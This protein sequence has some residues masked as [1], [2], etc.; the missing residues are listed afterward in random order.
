MIVIGVHVVITI[1]IINKVNLFVVYEQIESGNRKN[2]KKNRKIDEAL[3]L[4]LLQQNFF[5]VLKQARYKNL[6]K[7]YNAT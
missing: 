2:N 1:Y 5:I 7:F 6:K 4:M 3:I